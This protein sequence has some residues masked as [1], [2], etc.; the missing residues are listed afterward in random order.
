MENC[1]DISC[2]TVETHQIGN[3][4]DK[5]NFGSETA[6]TAPTKL[7][8]KRKSRKKLLKRVLLTHLKKM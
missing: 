5:S 8:I 3:K 4:E 1:V 2:Q 7:K 6:E